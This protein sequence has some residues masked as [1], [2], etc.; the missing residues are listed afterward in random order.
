MCVGWNA[1]ISYSLMTKL[2]EQRVR[3]LILFQIKS[4]TL[5]PSIQHTS[6]EKNYRVFIFGI[7]VDG[8]VNKDEREAVKRYRRQH[9]IPKEM[10]EKVLH[11][12]YLIP[13]ILSSLS[14][15][16]YLLLLS[17]SIPLLF[18]FT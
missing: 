3:L 6:R 5:S 13:S 11:V 9:N 10:H 1:F 7:L 18:S 2:E 17:F 12:R 8:L 4:L 14:S 15:F 16:P